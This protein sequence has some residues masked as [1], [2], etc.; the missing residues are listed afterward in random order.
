MIDDVHTN[1]KYPRTVWSSKGW[2]VL[3][4]QYFSDNNKSASTYI[5]N[6]QLL[7]TTL[8]LVEKK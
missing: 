8:H 6:Y 2:Q 5:R 4:K 1:T 3:N 7:A